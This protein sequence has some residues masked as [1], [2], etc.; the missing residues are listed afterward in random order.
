MTGAGIHTA[1]IAGKIA[2][3]VC[4]RAIEENDLNRERLS[5]YDDSYNFAYEDRLKTA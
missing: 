2:G 1:L 3:E 4:A 5:E